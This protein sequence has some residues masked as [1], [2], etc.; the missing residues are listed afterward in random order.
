VLRSVFGE[1]IWSR[2]NS[3]LLYAIGLALLVGV[4][5][6]VYPT[7]REGS[8]AFAQFLSSMP[9]GMISFLG[10][11]DI[12]Q[13]LSP[14]GFINSRVNAS[15]GSVVLAVFAI[16]LGTAAIAGEEEK[17]TMDLILATPTPRWR[18]VLERFAAMVTLVAT[19]AATVAL[20]MVIASPIVDLGLSTGNVLA[21]NLELAL[22]ALVFGS[23]A[24]AVG[25]L[26]G[27]RGLTI[28]IAAGTTVTAFFING[29]AGLVDWLKGPQKVTPFYW[30]Q[31][32]DPLGNGL[33]VEDTLIMVAVIAVF[34]TVTLWAF[35]RRD[36]SM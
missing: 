14:A 9:K 30:L 8:D 12:A 10:S 32:S 33:S 21:S 1:T 29:L 34:L 27:R 3:L 26:T 20:V 35:A 13:M 22:L 4:T 18:L 17:R 7:V 5:V 28:G 36:I 2:R 31:R 15:V 16:S 24:L 11:S 25:G 6:G 19:V 23:L